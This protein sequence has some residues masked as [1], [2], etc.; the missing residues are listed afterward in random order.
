MNTTRWM[1]LGSII[2]MLGAATG[3]PVSAAADP[4]NDPPARSSRKASDRAPKPA[5]T[6]RLAL[7]VTVG[8]SCADVAQLLGAVNRLGDEGRSLSFDHN[9]AEG[10]VTVVGPK[11]IIKKLGRTM[12]TVKMVAESGPKKLTPLP[13]PPAVPVL[14][15]R[16]FEIRHALARDLVKTID[17]LH[18]TSR[19]P[20]VAVADS[21]SNSLVIK[22]WPDELNEAAEVI[23]QL[24]R[25]RKQKAQVIAPV[26]EIVPLA[27]AD[28]YELRD[29]ILAV[30]SATRGD[31]DIV[32]IIPDEPTNSLILVGGRAQIHEARRLITVFDVAPG[33]MQ[34]TPAQ[35]DGSQMDQPARKQTSKKKSGRSKKADPKRKPRKPKGR[36]PADQSST[37]EADAR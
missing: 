18:R 31:V 11:R 27:H 14:T 12:D 16:V 36:T 7:T 21:S 15:V 6:E 37:A 2:L 32:D 28:A 9:N 33:E 34:F 13:P 4:K 17:A 20:W 30:A 1:T 24:D 35:N 29:V 5:S 10:T 22:G 23:A 19:S 3:A 25:P 26:V 8:K